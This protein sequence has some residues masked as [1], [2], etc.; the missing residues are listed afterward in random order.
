V[1]IFN[2]NDKENKTVTFDYDEES[3]PQLD[4]S[5]FRVDDLI[6]ELV[7]HKSKRYLFASSYNHVGQKTH[8][9]R[10]EMARRLVEENLIDDLEAFREHLFAKKDLLDKQIDKINLEIERLDR[11][12]Y[13]LKSPDLSCQCPEDEQEPGLQPYGDIC[14]AC[15]KPIRR[16]IT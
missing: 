5:D 4:V 9:E 10:I 11:E 14:V 3:A 15:G 1:L 16:P 2:E 12:V 7:E 13:D 8:E 6:E